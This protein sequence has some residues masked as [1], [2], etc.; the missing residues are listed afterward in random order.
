[1]MKRL[2]LVFLVFLASC[3]KTIKEEKP[4]TLV[5]AEEIVA[6]MEKTEF[7][8]SQAKQFREDLQQELLRD[9]ELRLTVIALLHMKKD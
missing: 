9:P 4:P 8:T 2:L 5:R 1:M 6:R 3:S 7:D